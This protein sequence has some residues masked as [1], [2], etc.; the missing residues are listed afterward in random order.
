MSNNQYTQLDEE[1]LED[2][3]NQ[4]HFGPLCVD[5]GSEATSSHPTK[6][7]LVP[8]EKFIY[9]FRPEWEEFFREIDDKLIKIG[10]HYH[11]RNPNCDSKANKFW[12]R[13]MQ[14][15]S[16]LVTCNN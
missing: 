8:N 6:D 12:G 9:N 3:S 16:W 10:Q 14:M 4:S 2:T 5:T 15:F 1:Y 7:P 13:L 11:L